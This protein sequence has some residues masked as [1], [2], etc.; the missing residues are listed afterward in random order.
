[1]ERKEASSNSVLLTESIRPSNIEG[2][3]IIPRK[4]F[5]SPT[6]CFRRS[7][8]QS[9]KIV[10]E[11]SQLEFLIDW[12]PQVVKCRICLEENRFKYWD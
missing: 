11:S 12:M 5:G 7:T 10:I 9:T 8:I 3:N 6:G 4:I 1:M 2:E